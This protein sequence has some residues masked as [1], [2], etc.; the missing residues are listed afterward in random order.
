MRWRAKL[1]RAGRRK[2]NARAPT[3]VGGRVPIHILCCARQVRAIPWPFS[4]DGEPSS[5]LGPSEP[6]QRPRSA[7]SAPRPDSQALAWS[8]RIRHPWASESQPDLLGFSR[9]LPQVF[10]TTVEQLQLRPLAA[11]FLWDTARHGHSPIS[12]ALD[13]PVRGRPYRRRTNRERWRC[14]IS[15]LALSEDEEKILW[16]LAYAS[17]SRYPAVTR[18]HLER[19]GEENG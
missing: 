18:E 5:Q 8:S 13:T 4:P 19:L 15:T 9:W 12:S 2:R 3:S 7:A 10:R 6:D 11:P 16:A 14:Q 17:G 1:R